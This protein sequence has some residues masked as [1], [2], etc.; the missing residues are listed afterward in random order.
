M[1]QL[2]PN[3]EPHPALRSEYI[4]AWPVM[5]GG[6]AVGEYRIRPIT[7][8]D[9]AGVL[10]LFVHLSAKSRYFRY[11]HAMSTLPEALLN[12]II[13]AT[14]KDDL[15]LVAMIQNED[16]SETLAGIARFIKDVHGTEGE[17]SLSVSD[18]HHRE[19]IGSHLI[20]S[21]VDC[22][23]L[24]GLCTIY[25]QVDKKNADMISLMRHL[26][27][28]LKTSE[29]DPHSFIACHRNASNKQA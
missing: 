7:P 24:N 20:Q 22:S 29:E 11:A 15:A 12:A 4:R 17:F 28:D 2:T 9:R 8:A 19:G 3:P 21:I 13:H 14:K 16:G 26:K 18:E 6:I 23:K 27:F 5:I 25:G 1:D 10:D